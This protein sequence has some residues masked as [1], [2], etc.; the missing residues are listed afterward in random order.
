MNS[1]KAVSGL[2]GV[3]LSEPSASAVEIARLAGYDTVVLDVEHGSFDLSALNWFL[4][5]IRS[6]G[7]EIIVK[8]LGPQREAIQQALDLGADAVAIPHVE[9]VEHARQVCGYAKFPPHGDRSFAGGRTSAYRGFN[10]EWVIEQDTQTKCYPMIED[11]SAFKDITAILGLP[12]V[13]GIFIGPSDLSLRRDRGAYSAEPDDL[14]D[15]QHLAEAANAAGKP[16][17]LPAWSPQEQKLALEKGAH[18]IILTM[19]YGAL[20]SGFE[21][22]INSLKELEDVGAR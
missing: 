20:L 22:A 7:M 19:Q 18:L 12:T 8:V 21:G 2:H 9:S 13:D 3:W 17:I 16:W 1:N 15:L 4:P 14:A 10:D 11:A 6:Q 5:F